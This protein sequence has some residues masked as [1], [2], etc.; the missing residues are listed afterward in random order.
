MWNSNVSVAVQLFVYMTTIVFFWHQSF[1]YL[2]LEPEFLE[3][4]GIGANMRTTDACSD[5]FYGASR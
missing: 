5:Q 1:V 3:T 4:F 2:D